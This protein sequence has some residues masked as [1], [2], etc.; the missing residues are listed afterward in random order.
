MYR[1]RGLFWPLLLIT[2]GVV[3]LLVNLNVIDSR[4]AFQLVNLWPLLLVLLGAEVIV[5]RTLPRRAVPLVSLVLTVA[6]LAG[7]LAYVLLAPAAGAAGS[8]RSD[9]SDRL[10]GLA[11]GSLDLSFG[12]ATIQL[13]GGAL[14]EDLYR[15]HFEIRQNEQAP[16]TQLDRSTGTLRIRQRQTWPFAFGAPGRDQVELSLSDRIPW[17]LRIVGGAVDSTLDLTGLKI[18]RL[19]VS[20]GANHGDVTLPSPVGSIPVEISG[21][22]TTVTL[23]LS[24]GSAARVRVSGGASDLEVDGNHNPGIGDKTWQSDGY[25]QATDRFDVQVSGGANHVRVLTR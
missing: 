23:H 13:R 25:S 1:Y 8:Q 10:E 3:A 4:A 21:G 14:G 6:V 22:A 12:A 15:A 5:S 18:S 2:I 24:P 19:R 7:A 11:A 17:N 16:L 20:G 9:A